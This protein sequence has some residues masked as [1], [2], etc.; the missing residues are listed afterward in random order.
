MMLLFLDNRTSRSSYT[1]IPKNKEKNKNGVC[2][3]SL[4]IRFQSKKSIN[5]LRLNFWAH[6]SPIKHIKM[7]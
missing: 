4:W 5:E 1:L 3:Y 2:V 6:E 7:G